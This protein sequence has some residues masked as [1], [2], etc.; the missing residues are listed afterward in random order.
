MS[1][2]IHDA[3]FLFANRCATRRLRPCNH[4]MCNV[5]AQ[6]GVIKKCPVPVC[7]KKVLRVVGISAPMGAPGM[8]DNPKLPVVLLD[9]NTIGYRREPFVS[10]VRDNNQPPRRS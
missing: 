2:Y 6:K 8:E 3:R 9:V 1:T 4:A 7:R 10:V 5:C